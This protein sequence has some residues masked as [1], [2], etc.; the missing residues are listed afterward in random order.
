M[1]SSTRESR[2]VV[3][4][5]GLS[6]LT[7]DGEGPTV[8]LLHGFGADR[9]TWLLTQREVSQYASTI[10]L[11]LPGHGQSDRDVG[12]GDVAFLADLTAAFLAER[13]TGPVHIVGHSLGG[14]IAID[15]AHR[16]PEWVASLFLIAPA[17]L[18]SGIDP[19]FL[20]SVT[21][22]SEL[23]QATIVLERLVT[24]RRLISPQMTARVLEQLS[25]PGSRE[26][27][28]K[29]ARS[30][31]T[32]HGDLAEAVAAVGRRGLPIHVM[33]GDSDT[34]NPLEAGCADALGADLQRVSDAG[35][36]PH[37][38]SAGAVNRAIRD[39]ILGA[40]DATDGA[41]QA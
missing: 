6:F 34:V 13:Q 7:T 15:L 40:T 25:Q 23:D 3:E 38:E 12:D 39:F 33:W 24:R 4:G 11:D 26:A 35:H 36:L 31:T 19:E 30:L 16:R 8:L 1:S 32:I 17:G 10:A 37:I 29:V 27:L 9:L 28:R 21:E 20:T 5:R 18:G 14:A 2:A 41:P 22:M